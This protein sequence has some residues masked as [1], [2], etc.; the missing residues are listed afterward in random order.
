VEYLRV[1]FWDLFYLSIIIY[2]NDL[3]DVCNN[4]HTKLYI[5]A[6]NT[7]LYRHICIRKDQEKLQNDIHRV[8]DW[9]SEWLLKLNVD[10]RRRISFTA[11]VN[12]LCDTQ[13][14]IEDSRACHELIKVDSVS[15][16]GVRFDFKLCF[17]DH[18][19][20]KLAKPTLS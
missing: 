15:D 16:L 10:K 13:Y 5:N 12:S 6:D 11:N 1:A 19:N 17:S 8:T 18:V 9:A 7:K 14:Y 20:E 2:I 4:V 3:P